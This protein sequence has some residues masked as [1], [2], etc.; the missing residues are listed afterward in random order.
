MDIVQARLIQVMEECDELS[1]R[2]SKAARFGLKEVQ[3]G[4]DMNNEE[5]ILYE[6]NDLFAALELLIGCDIEGMVDRRSIDV[7]KAKIT[8]YLDYSKECGTVK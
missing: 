3:K 7:K 2:C 5:R 1:Q 6:L 4:Q 8:K